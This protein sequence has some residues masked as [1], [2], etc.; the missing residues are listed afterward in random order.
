MFGRPGARDRRLSGS[1][2]RLIARAGTAKLRTARPA[3][4]G[5][6]QSTE[7]HRSNDW[8]RWF[9]S[10][11]DITMCQAQAATPTIDARSRFPD[12]GAEARF[13]EIRLP[14]TGLRHFGPRG[15]SGKTEPHL[16]GWPAG[17]RSVRSMGR[18]SMST[19]QQNTP[20]TSPRGPKVETVGILSICG[21]NVPLKDCPV[22]WDVQDRH[23]LQRLVRCFCTLKS[24][25]RTSPWERVK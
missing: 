23:G 6:R 17:F 19:T 22:V 3:D 14:G 16:T 12:T 15:S 24:W 1:W 4:R 21:Q 9:L 10:A 11:A 25:L 20:G 5:D 7:S 18:S 8:W 13:G 2:Q